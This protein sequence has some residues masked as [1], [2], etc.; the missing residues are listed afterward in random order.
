MW[1]QSPQVILRLRESRRRAML[2]Q[3]DPASSI[4]SKPNLSSLCRVEP[5]PLPGIKD[6]GVF[7]AASMAKRGAAAPGTVS[8]LVA[9]H[10]SADHQAK[11]ASLASKAGVQLT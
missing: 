4:H 8:A 3:R 9:A 1:S 6:A 11:L 2:V 7:L 5:D 10:V